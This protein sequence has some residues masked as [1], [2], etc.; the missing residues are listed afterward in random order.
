MLYYPKIFRD[1]LKGIRN[2]SHA[3]DKFCFHGIFRHISFSLKAFKKAIQN[4]LF[5][6]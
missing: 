4:Q 6:G 5:L 3:K 1:S 2:L